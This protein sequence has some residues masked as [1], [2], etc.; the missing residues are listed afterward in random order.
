MSS[1]TCG[2]DEWGL[3]VE[4]IPSDDKHRL[5]IHCQMKASLQIKAAEN[6]LWFSFPFPGRSEL[7]I[8]L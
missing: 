5:I 2:G 7:S 1:E 8:F 4:S 6:F 3:A